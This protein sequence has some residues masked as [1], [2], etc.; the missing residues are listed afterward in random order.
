MTAAILGTPF[1]GADGNHKTVGIGILRK[2]VDE[3]LANLIRVRCGLAE[4]KI[5]ILSQSRVVAEPD[6]QRHPTLDDPASGLRRLE[7]GDDALEHNSTTEA[8]H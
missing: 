3:A 8:V 1:R 2:R 4:P 6:L 7:P 5:Q